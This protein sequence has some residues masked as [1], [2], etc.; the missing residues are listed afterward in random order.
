MSA[1]VIKS[2]LSQCR[3]LGTKSC[4]TVDGDVCISLHGSRFL[5]KL[6]VMHM[7]ILPSCAARLPLHTSSYASIAELGCCFAHKTSNITNGC[8]RKVDPHRVSSDLRAV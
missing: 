4:R 5:P 1:M 3:N 2:A 7:P 8:T 6:Q